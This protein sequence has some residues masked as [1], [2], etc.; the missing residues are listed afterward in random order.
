MAWVNHRRQSQVSSMD[1]VSTRTTSA[2]FLAAV[3]AE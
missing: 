3:T 2:P 1:F